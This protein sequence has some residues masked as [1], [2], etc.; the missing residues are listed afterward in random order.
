M[1]E[2]SERRR[3][4]D[5]AAVSFNMRPRKKPHVALGDC[6]PLLAKLELENGSRPR[7]KC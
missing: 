6:G 3:R 7:G 5:N 1:F 4:N 2:C